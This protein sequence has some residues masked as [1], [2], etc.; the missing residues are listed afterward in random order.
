MAER[1]KSSLSLLVLSFALLQ[2]LLFLNVRAVALAPVTQEAT[3]AQALLAWKASLENHSLLNS[4]SLLNN[5]NATSTE[6]KR[7]CTCH[8]L[9]ITCNVAGRITRINLFNASLRVSGD[10]I[11]AYTVQV[12]AVKQLDRNGLQGLREFLVVVLMPSVL[13]HQNLVNLIG[14]CADGDQRLLAQP[15]FKDPKRFPELADPSLQGDFP[16]KGLN[17]AVA[18]AVMCLQEEASVRPLITDV[19]IALSFLSDN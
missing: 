3:E 17:Q 13:H 6:S 14:Y 1:K 4:W 11:S 18:I 19:V 7:N 10:P 16:A 8:W 15:Y 2:L 12:V 5:S 9:G